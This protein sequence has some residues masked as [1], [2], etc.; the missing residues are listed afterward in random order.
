M[1]QNQSRQN[2]EDTSLW[3]I[4]KETLQQWSAD[5]ATRLAA[6]LAYYTIFSMAPLVIILVAM[7]GFFYGR[8]AVTGQIVSQ[9][10][11]FTNDISTAEFIQ[12][13]IRDV[14]SPG[15]SLLATG[16]GLIGLLFGATGVFH[17]LKSAINTIWNIED[18]NNGIRSVV[19]NRLIAIAMVPLS[20]LLLLL[21][22]IANTVLNAAMAWFNTFSPQMAAISQAANFLFFLVLTALIFALIYRYLPDTEVAWGDVWIGA[23]ATAVLFSIGRVLISIYLSLSTIQS[24]YGAA[25]SLMVTLLWI[26]YSAQIFFLG[27]EFTQVYATTYGSR[28]VPEGDPATDASAEDRHSAPQPT[29]RTTS[30]QAAPP[31]RFGRLRKSAS[32]LA[33]AVLIIG[34]VSALTFVPRRRAKHNS[35]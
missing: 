22:L 15:T 24:T 13:L 29:A 10:A 19:M 31:G 27:A 9:I 8:Q 34:A 32:N 26:Y 7:V 20:G 6:A 18:Q 17:E 23:W 16:I 14:A 35:S 1:N 5:N 28:T 4:V 25:G 30:S 21:S 33:T 12:S 11:D 3:F 2:N